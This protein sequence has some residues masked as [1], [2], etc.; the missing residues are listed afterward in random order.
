M[1]YEFNLGS[2][3]S[4]EHARLKC[5]ENNGDLVHGLRGVTPTFLIGEL[6]RR[7]EKIKAQLIWIGVKKD[8][9]LTSRTWR[10]VNGK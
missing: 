5:Q 7:R 2:G 3:G 1:C 9:G 4:F 6:D 10:W 8:P